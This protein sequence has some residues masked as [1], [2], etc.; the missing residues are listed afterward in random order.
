MFICLYVF[1]IITPQKS[2]PKLAENL[3]I[4]EII[5]KREDLH[6]Y[7]SHKGRSIPYMIEKYVEQGQTNFVI[8]SSGNAALAAIYAINDLDGASLKIFV[9]KNIDKDKLENL[10]KLITNKNISIEQVERPKQSAFQL[11][12]NGQAKSLRQSTDDLALEG[13]RSLAEELKELKNLQAIFIPT[14]SGTTAQALGE[15]NAEIHIV[16]TEVC[17]P[18][19]EALNIISPY[20][21]EKTPA[22]LA[23]R[24]S[25]AGA[26]VD[27]I[28]HRKEKIIEI[29][30][31]SH[32]SG[33]VVSDQEI[34]EAI[35]LTKEKTDIDISGNSALSIAGLKKAVADG[36]KWNGTVV[37]LITGK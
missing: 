6:P 3:E 24:G 28:A 31:N 13:Y 21:G 36:W 19:V 17:H 7:G 12:R 5:L 8:S 2:Y 34:E 23:Q 37:S 1:M 26:I 27:K 16:Q 18:I 10:E 33:W 32:G 30:K 14:S 29:I 22:K 25:L 11:D 35:K 20:E 9:G 4:P 15:L